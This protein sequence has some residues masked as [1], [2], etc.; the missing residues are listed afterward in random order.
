MI[1]DKITGK[2]KELQ[3]IEKAFRSLILV[4]HCGGCNFISEIID[5]FYFELINKYS[6]ATAEMLIK[7]IQYMG[8]N[9]TY[10]L[11]NGINH[12]IREMHNL[13]ASKLFDKIIL[14]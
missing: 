11:A 1:Y 7:K 8:M 5:D 6:P 13:F 12:P 14:S 10:L 3:G 9:T 2:I 4:G